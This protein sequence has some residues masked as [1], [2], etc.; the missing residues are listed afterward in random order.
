[1]KRILGFALIAVIQ[2]CTNKSAVTETSVGESCIGTT[3]ISGE[4]SNK[5]KPIPDP[6]L[7]A[8]SLGEPLQGKLCQGAVYQNTQDV[9]IYRAWNSTNPNS[10]FGQWWA[11]ELPSGKTAE[12]RKNYEICY[13]WSP[14]DKLSKCTLKA[15]TKVVVGNGQSAECSAYLTYPVS[16]VQQLFIVDSGSSVVNCQ[17]YDSVISWE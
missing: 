13:Q 5:F 3:G 7:L 9:T 15:G 1:M 12:Y 2:G 16:E 6:S 10:Q 11:L 17:L 8:Q 4:L 14:L